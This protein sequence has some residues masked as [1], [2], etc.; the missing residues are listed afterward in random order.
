MHFAVSH[1]SADPKLVEKMVVTLSTLC[2][3]MCA[4]TRACLKV[5]VLQCFKLRKRF[6]EIPACWVLFR[7]REWET[8]QFRSFQT[9]RLYRRKGLLG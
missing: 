9:T 4:R 2:V 5:Q 7:A 3:R 6:K 1:T 8:L